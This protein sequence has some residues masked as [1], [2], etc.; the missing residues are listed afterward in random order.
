MNRVIIE[1]YDKTEEVIATCTFGDDAE[2]LFNQY[3]S[4]NSYVR[5][6]HVGLLG[7]ETM[8]EYRPQVPQ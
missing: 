1:R 6:E 4:L 7:T 2:L 5:V 8:L 3:K